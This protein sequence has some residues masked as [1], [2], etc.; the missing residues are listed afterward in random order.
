MAELTGRISFD[1]LEIT[2]PIGTFYVG[3]MKAS[4]LVEIAFSDVQTLTG[5]NLDSFLGIERPLSTKRVA[6]LEKYVTNVDATF[7]TGILIS[8]ESDDA[9][10]DQNTRVMTFARRPNVAKVLD[11]QHRIAGLKALSS[12]IFQVNVTIFVDMALEDQAMVFATINLKQTPV[13]RSLAYNLYEYATKRS[14]QK[15]CHDIAK[16]LNSKD[17]SPF[18]DKIKILGTVTPGRKGETLTQAAFVDNLVKLLSDDWDEDRDVL[19]R[20]RGK[21]DRADSKTSRRLV[22]RNMF[23][24]ERDAEIARVLSNYFGAVR[25]RWPVAWGEAGRGVVLNRTTG[26]VALMRLLP[27]AYLAIA[28]PGDLVREDKFL[29]IFRRSKLEDGD[30]TSERFVPGSSG[31]KRL[32]DELL[33]STG[34]ESLTE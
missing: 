12:G 26:L 6:E 1:C 28:E 27:R 7:P 32:L 33:E 2:Q 34:L 25:E 11:G 21:L 22:F 10:Y 8:V 18:K 14:P 29:A 3:V 20:P 16:L 9:E 31:Q 30:F 13:S 24:D 23:I 17:A 15:T 5:S 4:D 19:K